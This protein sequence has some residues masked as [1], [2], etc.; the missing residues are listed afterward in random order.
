MRKPLVFSVALVLAIGAEAPAAATPEP[1]RQARVTEFVLSAGPVK[2]KAVVLTFDDGPSEFTPGI[3]DTLRANRVPATFCLLGNNAEAKPGIARRIVNE[4]HQVCNH[5]RSHADLRRASA[6]RITDEVR[7]AQW[8]IGRATGVRPELFR[9][10]YG[11]SDKQARR[12]VED[13]GLRPLSWD[14]DPQDWTRPRSAAIA[15][16]VVQKSR[17]GSVILLHDGGGD[18]RHTAAALQDIID[19]LRKKGYRFTR[20]SIRP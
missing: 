19:G 15:E 17:P 1:E 3:L 7:V 13:A 5:T 20:P 11:A 18:R 14:V 9:F 8:E 2:Q 12:I 16:R 10:P 6:R 4:G